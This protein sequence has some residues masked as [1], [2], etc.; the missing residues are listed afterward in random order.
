[1]HLENTKLPDFL[2]QALNSALSMNSLGKWS[3]TETF[4]YIFIPSFTTEHIKYI[5]WF[6]YAAVG[7]VLTGVYRH[8]TAHRA[9]NQ[10]HGVTSSATRL[11]QGLR[12]LPFLIARCTPRSSTTL[13]TVDKNVFLT[14]MKIV[15][16]QRPEE[17]SWWPARL[18]GKNLTFAVQL[19]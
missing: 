19:L 3:E 10:T 12:A 15:Q 14:Q 18:P 7:W 8:R 2:C 16:P 4:P 5:S 11:M 6:I 1:M 17:E 9:V 13:S